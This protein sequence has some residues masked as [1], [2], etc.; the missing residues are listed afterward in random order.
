MDAVNLG[1]TAGAILLLSLFIKGQE[2]FI[3]CHAWRLTWRWKS[4]MEVC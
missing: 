4:V 2:F 3:V 1:G